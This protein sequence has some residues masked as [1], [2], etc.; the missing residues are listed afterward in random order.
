MR[1]NIMF[2]LELTGQVTLPEFTGDQWSDNGER[3]WIASFPNGYDLSIAKSA[4]HYCG[5]DSAEL[6]CYGPD[7]NPAWDDVRG[8]QTVDQIIETFWEVSRY[9]FDGKRSI[10]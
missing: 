9:R 8:W 7:G 2:D 1:G 10:R 4:R 6:Y 5:D 3:H